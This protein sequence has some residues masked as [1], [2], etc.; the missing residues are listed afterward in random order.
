[1]SHLV[2]TALR[3][4]SRRALRHGGA[5]VAVLV[6]ALVSHASPAAAQEITEVPIT[7][8]PSEDLTDGQTVTVSSEGWPVDI[9]IGIAM[10]VG[11]PTKGEDCDF[12]TR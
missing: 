7:V 5:L 6:V 3:R 1:M 12:A 9:A 4:P 10:C 2:P 8:T 11:E